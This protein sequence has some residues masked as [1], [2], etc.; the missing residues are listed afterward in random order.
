MKALF[1]NPPW[2]EGIEKHEESGER[3]WRCGVRAGSRWPHTILVRSAPDRL[4][5]KEYLPY[6]FFLGFAA[7][8]AQRETDA[9]VTFRDSI[10]LR[11][12][13]ESFYAHVEA[14]K[15][16][17]IFIETGS[18][19]L[20]HDLG[21]M[22][23]LRTLLPN[24][25]IVICGPIVNS[26]E[27]LKQ[28]NGLYHAA[29]K[30][31]YEK[32]SVRVLNGESGIIDY[33]LLTVEEMN[34]QP[35]PYMDSQYAKLYWDGVANRGTWPIMKLWGSRGCPYKCIFCVWPATMTG[36]DPDG[37][38]KRS[39]RHYSGRYLEA[40]IR[41]YLTIAPFSFIY[42]DDD[43]FN[44]GQKHVL[45]VCDAM[46]RVALPWGAMCRADGI[47]RDGWLRMKETGCVAVKIGF[48]S[49]NQW[50]VD[51]IV[52]K[53]LDLKEAR[54]TVHF[55]KSIDINVHGTFTFGLPGETAEQMA[56]TQAFIQSLPMDTYQT[57]GCAEIKGTPLAELRLKGNL[58]KYPGAAATDD[59]QAV[60]DGSRKMKKIG[61]TSTYAN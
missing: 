20:S 18:P 14:R 57:S 40:W 47:D 60:A 44:L 54:E 59:Y 5:Y 23:K 11:E 38:R 39:V 24:T 58:K 4:A 12:S 45:D 56:E 50:V 15:Y 43:T 55:L 32:G 25:K 36:N 37:S 10:A 31:E 49:G 46:E 21:V 48:E 34:S 30:G 51:N 6:P 26:P 29:I 16:D 22:A 13:Y 1:A 61:V 53:H 2:W 9:D 7:T 3:R 19:S 41:H 33:D 42:F 35:F 28:A 8:Y 52:N 27:E 17:F